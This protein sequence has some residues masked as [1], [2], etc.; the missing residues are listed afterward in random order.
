MMKVFFKHV[1]QV[2]FI[3]MLSHPILEIEVSGTEN[4]ILAWNLKKRNFREVVL[5][6]LSK[7]GKKRA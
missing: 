5:V 7:P 3:I 6:K 4:R 2:V 1:L